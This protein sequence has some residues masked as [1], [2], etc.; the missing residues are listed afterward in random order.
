M[1]SEICADILNK[2]TLIGVALFLSGRVFFFKYT[3]P[4]P[5]TYA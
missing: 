2:K 4:E 3:D 1:E 5:A